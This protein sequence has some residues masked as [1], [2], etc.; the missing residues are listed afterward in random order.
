MKKTTMLK[1]SLLLSIILSITAGICFWENFLQPLHP[2]NL[3][4]KIFFGYTLLVNVGVSIIA[5]FF[6]FCLIAV[7]LHSMFKVKTDAK[8]EEIMAKLQRTF[9]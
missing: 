5:A 2:T 6:S 4:E 1:V 8:E 3:E 7:K 9:S